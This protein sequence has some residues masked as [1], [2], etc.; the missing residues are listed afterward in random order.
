MPYFVAAFV[1]FSI[2][3]CTALLGFALFTTFLFSP[4]Q[5]IPTGRH[6]AHAPYAM[7][8]KKMAEKKKQQK[9]AERNTK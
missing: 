2:Y 9:E 6:A 5:K 3:F 7:G 1:A 4:R 8:K